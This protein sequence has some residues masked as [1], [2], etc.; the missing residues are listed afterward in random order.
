MTEPNSPAVRAWLTTR[1]LDG[2]QTLRLAETTAN[3]DY[4]KAHKLWAWT[5]LYDIAALEASV[6][7]ERERW[8]EIVEQLCA[9]HDEP[10]CPAVRLAREWLQ[11]PNIAGKRP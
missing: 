5:P 7:A 9:C 1:T 3:E 4:A 11:G 6:T 2:K 8:R 10:E